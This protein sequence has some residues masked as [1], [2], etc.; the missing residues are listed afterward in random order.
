MSRDLLLV[1]FSLDE[2]SLRIGDWKKLLNGLI[3]VEEVVKQLESIE[4]RI[5]QC[6]KA[7]KEPNISNYVFIGRAGTGKTTVAK[8]MSRMLQE[9]NIVNGKFEKTKALELQARYFGQTASKVSEILDETSGGVL[10]IDEAH[11]L[12]DT[13][14]RTGFMKEVCDTLLPRIEQS[15]KGRPVVILAGYPDEMELMFQ[16]ANEGLRG[17]FTER[18]VFPD[19]DPAD[20]IELIYR[21]CA[22]EGYNLDDMAARKLLKGL[23][24]IR[25]RS[26]WA[27]ARDAETA[28][29][30][31][32]NAMA[33]RLAKFDD[34]VDQRQV[35]VEDAEHAVRDFSLNRPCTVPIKGLYQMG[36]SDVFDVNPVADEQQGGWK[37]DG[38]ERVEEIEFVEIS[39]EDVVVFDDGG[40][41]K[42]GGKEHPAFTA[43]LEACVEAGY[44]ESHEKRQ[45]LVEIMKSVMD[46]GKDFPVE[47][48][49]IVRRKVESQGIK[50]AVEITRILR[51]QVPILLEGMAAAVVA[52]EE[53]LLEIKLREEEALRLDAMRRA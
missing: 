23:E 11:N 47:I 29:A 16:N 24:E 8:A 49:D 5:K 13:S 19:W 42:L 33:V 46:D 31:L 3:K 30:Y 43:L 21:K 2:E 4:A 53:R 1:D 41:R 9:L 35:T 20:C 52:E 26:G 17:R 51:P 38:V 40:G 10:F 14:A 25:T 44:D 50:T 6:R 22:A 18:I 45:K 36:K 48:M 27:N 37:E 39:S 12:A 15:V 34:S 7:N 28:Y 32:L